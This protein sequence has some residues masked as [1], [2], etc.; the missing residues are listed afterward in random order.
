[1]GRGFGWPRPERCPRCGYWKL[2]GHGFVSAYFEPYREPLW[3]RRYRCPACRLILR[4]KPSGYFER[5]QS[6]I[7]SIRESLAY[8]FYRHFWPP[9]S[10]RQRQGH[11]LRSLLK[12]GKLYFGLSGVERGIEVFDRLISLG[13]VA[14]SRS[15]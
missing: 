14:V 4:L 11:W 6:S 5:F 2:W 8:R 12:K 7:E 15:V 9:G 13:V 1:M 10:S 3:L